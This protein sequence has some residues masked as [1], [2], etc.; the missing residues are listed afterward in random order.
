MKT[1]QKVAIEGQASQPSKKKRLLKD[2]MC[3]LARVCKAIYGLD[4][5]ASAN[6]ASGEVPG[7][8]SFIRVVCVCVCVIYPERMQCNAARPQHIAQGTLDRASLPKRGYIDPP[9]LPN[10]MILVIHISLPFQIL[11]VSCS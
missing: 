9:P 6:H 3:R 5:F 4:M 10:A 11:T 7:G 1:V 8:V 2:M